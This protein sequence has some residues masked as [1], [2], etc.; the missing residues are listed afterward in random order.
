MK[1]WKFWAQCKIRDIKYLDLPSVI[2]KPKKEVFAKVKERVGKKLS[3][4][5]EN[6][7]SNGRKEILIKAMAQA[8]ST[9]TMSYFQ[10]P[11]GLYEEIEGMMRRFWWGQRQQESKIVWVSWKNMCKSKLRG[12]MRFKD[13]QAFNLAMLAR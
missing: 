6:M 3:G 5:K 2:G 12:G 11:K 1:C 8:I 7:L 4:W 13:L 9:Y 10:L